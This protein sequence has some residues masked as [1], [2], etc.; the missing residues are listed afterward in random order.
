MTT[1]LTEAIPK[2]LTTIDFVLPPL[3]YSYDALEP[4]IDT[5]TMQIHHDGHHQAYVD[6]ANASLAGS[7]LAGESATKILR[8][9]GSFDWER[10]ALVRDNV[11]GHINHSFFWQ[12]LSPNKMVPEG[13]LLRAIEGK[14]KSLEA[15]KEEFNT[16]AIAHFASGWAWLVLDRRNE[17]QIITTQNQ[18]APIIDGLEPIL[19]L[20]LWEHAYYLQYQNRRM[21]YVKNWWNIVNWKEAGDFYIQALKGAAQI[22]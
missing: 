4:Y 8:S 10:R 9:L 6:K 2:D 18:D 20:D 19:G 3:P 22:N 17:P 12:I 13:D 11:G 5:K 7:P 14:F 16:R 21:E 1:S 15:F